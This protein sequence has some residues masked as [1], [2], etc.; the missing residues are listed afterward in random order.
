MPHGVPYDRGAFEAPSAIR[1]S[2]GG[3]SSRRSPIRAGGYRGM[4]WP[5][6][7]SRVSV[8]LD[9]EMVERARVQLGLDR[10]SDTTVVDRALTPRLRTSIY[11]QGIPEEIIAAVDMRRA[12][13]MS[14]SA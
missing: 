13:M 14:A 11:L 1:R 12:P 8:E 5:G 6:A 9:E 10:A 4:P 7:K 2:V 3:A